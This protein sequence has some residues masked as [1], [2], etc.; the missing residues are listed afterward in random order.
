M[1]GGKKILIT[2]SGKNKN[3]ETKYHRHHSVVFLFPPLIFLLI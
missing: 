2:I 3:P 1:P